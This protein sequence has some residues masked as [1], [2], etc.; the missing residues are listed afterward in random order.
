MS[1]LFSNTFYNRFNLSNKIRWISEKKN[2]L[3]LQINVYIRTDKYNEN[4]NERL[5]RSQTA[6]YLHTEN[7]YSDSA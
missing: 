1:E 5:F 2:L 3:V 7:K 4:D 6:H